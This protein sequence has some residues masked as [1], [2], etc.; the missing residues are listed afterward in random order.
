MQQFILAFLVCASVSL[1]AAPVLRSMSV[2]RRDGIIRWDDDKSE[3]A[4]F[5]VNYYAPFSV[6]FRGIRQLGLQHEEVIRQDVAHFARLGLDAIRL[7]CWDREISDLEGNLVDNEHLRL[8][9]FLI[10]EC[11]KVGI[12]TVLTPMAWWQTSANY[13]GFATQYKD[14]RELVSDRDA[15]VKQARYLEQF[16]NHVNRYRG[17]RYADDEA[18]AVFELINEPLYPENYSNER[19]TEYINTLANAVRK[20][21]TR[22][23]IFYCAWANRAQACADADI[24]GVS[25]GWYPT[26]LVAGHMLRGNH[27]NV[28][29]NYPHLQEPCLDKK[30]K[31]IYEFDAAD[32]HASYVYPAFA[33]EFRRVGVQ[34]ATQFQYDAMV[35][36]DSNCNWKTHYLNLAYTPAK[37][38]S[39]AIAA[40]AFRALPRGSNDAAKQNEHRFAHARIDAAADLSQWLDES[41]FLYS[42]SNDSLPPA[43]QELRRIWGVGSSAL[44]QYQGNGAYFLDKI[45]DGD[46]LLEVYPDTVTLRDPYTGQTNHQGSHTE[47]VRLLFRDNDLRLSLPDLTGDLMLQQLSGRKRRLSPAPEIRRFASDSVFSIA[48]GCYRIWRRGTRNPLRMPASVRGDFVLPPQPNRHDTALR[49]DLPV[50]AFLADEALPVIV[51]GV[52][53]HAT[54]QVSL[55]FTHSGSL[56]SQRIPMTADPS[57]RDHWLAQ[58]KSQDLDGSGRYQVRIEVHGQDGG[59]SFPDG[60]ALPE[61][62]QL[63]REALSLIDLTQPVKLPESVRDEQGI[64]FQ[65][66]QDRE[67]G[68]LRMAAR[69]YAS[70]PDHSSLYIP[71]TAAALAAMPKAASQANAIRI[72]LRGAPQSNR[73]QLLLI[74][75]D[76]QAFATNLSVA[77][78][79]STQNVL[80]D[81]FHPHES[82]SID[83]IDLARVARIGLIAGKWLYR[84]LADQ[85]HHFEIKDCSLSYALPHLSMIV[86]D[87]P[88]QPI[89]CEFSSSVPRAGGV[90]VSQR[91]FGRDP[92]SAAAILASSGFPIAG[93]STF[94]LATLPPCAQEILQKRQDFNTLILVARAVQP[95]TNRLELVIRE[96]D[97]SP[98]GTQA[99]TLSEDWQEIHIPLKSLSFFKHWKPACPPERGG[100]GDGLRLQNARRIN[101]CYGRW[102]LGEDSDKSQSIAIQ[103]VR[104]ANIP[105]E[106]QIDP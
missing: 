93:S 47:K 27:L 103:E 8:L 45:A 52:L 84:D 26:G 5:G 9:D 11:A 28:V 82:A 100:E 101:F 18:V 30:A 48:P 77:S 64:L 90:G 42:N 54:D 13:Q 79:W 25:H 44:V 16:V 31:I 62:Q 21:G 56:Q 78:S 59:L 19:V 106:P 32:V 53:A 50:Q 40:E 6:D 66:S 65:S 63:M 75:D 17:K 89:I 41:S 57:R 80:I 39:F 14:I 38:I 4:L 74:Q 105:E 61:D 72:T 92:D 36:A 51:E 102:L 49:T 98:W 67:N 97:G 10:D 15:W 76:G 85:P 87:K 83:K 104:L 24:D 94:L 34:I 69:T 73:L 46:W 60:I 58:I 37:A 86:Q 2:D 7:H 12:Y 68:V 35:M 95:W 20:S 1:S 96:E 22:K 43:P 99:I 71:F 33:R 91:S 55:V 88:L 3:V 29:R 23:A 70:K 81:A